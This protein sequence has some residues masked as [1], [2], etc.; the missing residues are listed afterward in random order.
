VFT[1]EHANQTLPFVERVVA[2]LVAQ[3]KKVCALEEKCH[4]HRPTVSKEEHER[5]RDQYRDGLDRLRDLADELSSVGCRL[6]DWRRGI[7]DF[8]TV[9][10][11]RRIE[12]C[13]RLGQERIE[14]WHEM[15]D[16][17]PGRMEIDDEFVAELARA[18]SPCPATGPSTDSL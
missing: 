5:I 13:W 12:F 4:V 7:V 11:G 18:D 16:G 17:F 3:Y 2:D 8:P 15:D 10:R 1:L 6:K 14:F 9:Y